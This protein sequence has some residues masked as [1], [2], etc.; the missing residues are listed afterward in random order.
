MEDSDENKK[1][2]NKILDY[3]NKNIHNNI[4]SF[5][6]N[7]KNEINKIIIY[8]FTNIIESINNENLYCYD[9]KTLGEIKQNN[10]KQIRISAIQNEFELETEIEEFLEN[11][12]LKLF[13]L[14]L[15]PYECSTID[16]LK[17]I[18]ENKETEYKNK[19]QEKINKL[20]LFIVHLERISKKDS[21]NK[22]S[23]NWDL[24]QKKTLTHSLS[25]LAGYTQVFID[26]ING[27]DYLD[28][29]CKIIS[30]EKMLKMK[31][32][33][34]YQ[35][36][37]N[38]E[39]IFLENL[40][41]VLFFYDYNFNYNE[42]ELNRDIYITK[43]I[44][45]FIEDK[46]LIN[47][48]DEK[49]MEII[50]SKN[51]DVN[52]K[53]KNILEKIIQEEKFSRG[54]I[55]IYDIVKK[56]L[57][58]N[59]LNE[60]KVLYT[61]L[62]K[63]YY[64]SNLIFNKK[65]NAN[66]DDDKVNKIIKEIF[67][68]NVDIKDKVP[69]NE[70]KI[71]IIIG[72]NLPSKNLIEEII[73][74][75]NNNIINQYRQN[76][77]EFKNQYFEKKQYEN[78]LELCNK[79]TQENIKKNNIIKEIEEKLAKGEKII[80]YDKF[81]DLLFEDYLLYFIHKN[82]KEFE[83]KK[84]INIK[85]FIK[86]ILENKFNLNDNKFNLEILS[87]L[88]NWIE[89]YSME[90]ISIINMYLFLNKYDKSNELNIKI[91]DTIPELNKEYDKLEISNNMKLI[92]RTFYNIIDSLINILICNLNKILSEIKNQESLKD[93]IDNLNNVY[94]SL[95]LNNNLLNLSSKGIHTLHETIKII[96]ILSFNESEENKKSMIDFI[97]K[98][99]INKTK[100][101][102][103]IIEG[104]KLKTDNDNNE[105]EDTEEEKY[106]K[107][108]LD[109]FYK[110]YKGK[111]N[112]N[113]AELFSSVLFDEFKKEYNEKYRQYLLKKILDDDN[114]IQYNILLIK[115]IIA[116]YIKPNKEIIDNVLDYISSEE[117]YFPFLNDC[118]K[119]IVNKIIINI[120][121]TTINLYFNSLDNLSENMISDLFDIFVEYLKVISN[122][123]YE[124]YYDNYCNEKLVK[125]Y[126]LSFIKIYLNNFV[127][128]LCDKRT[129][130][131]KNENKII[132]EI[133][134]NSSI[135]N[136]IKIYFIILLYNK[137]KS[138]NILKEDKLYEP[139][140]GFANNLNNLDNII[141]NSKIPTDDNY[142]FHEYFTYIKYPSFENLKSKFLSLYA[143]KEKFPLINEYIKNDQGPNN[144]KDLNDYNDF[145]NLMVSY[146]SG[147]IQRNEANKAERSLDNEDIYKKDENN[148][149]DKFDK[150][151]SIYNNVLSPYIKEI[152][153]KELKSDKF[154]EKLEANG[155]LAYFLID[156]DDKDYGIFIAI[157][158]NKFI[159]WQNSF[160][161]PIIKAYKS[162]K[163]NLLSCYFPQMEKEVNVQNA[164][165]LQ[166]LQLENCFFKSFFINFEELFSLY[167]E[168]NNDNKNDFNYDFEKIEEELGKCLLPNKCLFNE[169]NINYICY[170]NEGFRNIN[171]DYLIKFGEKYGE[172]ELTEE[173]RKKIFNYANKEFNNFD[174]LYDSFILL[175]NYLNNIS[176]TKGM[177][178]IDFI[179]QAQKRHINFSN[180]FI[181][182]FK[183][184]GKEIV[185]EKLLSSFLYMEHICYDHL[186]D[187]IDIKFK[188][189]FDKGQ[190]K[191]IEEYFASKFK[192]AIITQKE[193]ASAVR[194]FI[195]R[196]LLNDDKKEKIDSNLS[197]YDCLKRKYL[198]NNKI[199]SS[200]GN[201]LDFNDLIKKYLGSFKFA[202]EARYSLEFYNLIGEE[203]KNFIKEEKDKFAGKETKK[204][205]NIIVEP[206]KKVEK[207][208][209]IGGKKPPVPGGPKMKPKK[210]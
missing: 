201:N 188:S 180:Q 169:K 159:E 125:I 34:L 92:N 104:P 184:E 69:E 204:E 153:N 26:D 139:F 30:L 32:L 13:I 210:K 167:A 76:E 62:E 29:E 70:M 186:I 3:Y 54:D 7:F 40:Y 177:K 113:F 79:I 127:T 60:F 161:K 55:C 156:S 209:G 85:S 137:T 12:N 15:L 44:E 174:I 45:L 18:I 191:E 171:Y 50:N 152:N 74:N 87:A 38:K 132:E 163:N 73:L 27:K 33:E 56:I 181:N 134:N 168:R 203:E 14:N 86:I 165:N 195:I 164:N 58:K 170:Q 68:K 157:G 147:K 148:F 48:L 37:I 52:C 72:F 41:S 81:Y 53:N 59:Y 118:D 140:D 130:L 136:T 23:E 91:K 162:R 175:V 110:F 6:S 145:V 120:F 133:N 103:K 11:K 47:L 206:K 192:D 89:T 106:L 16:Y 22:Y 189:T 126:V 2:Y 166:I 119:D 172:K 42:S 176:T 116:E 4:K 101:K 100:E 25:N 65:N 24:I 194:R 185:I 173:E 205:N 64:F 200:L 107:N 19:N 8:T 36:F 20:F 1:F 96:S 141:K 77:E 82:I 80:F 108:N 49:I 146:Y 190:K 35:S 198:W 160:L 128:L 10:I 71:D 114:L 129:S 111:N 155:R 143:N 187:K 17:I 142:L 182:Y 150:F 154:L 197:L 93:L 75:I 31:N 179:N 109:N 112:I 5:L 117:N 158:L 115:L 208:S 138:L 149:R 151:K 123:D 135:S 144:L 199:F 28:N 88:L 84:I 183:E 66:N 105:T 122:N 124:K 99:I 63:N 61:E 207:T 178:I 51:D 94:Y 193:I 9:I 57:N 67:I 21:G 131:K 78:D 121:D 97:Q 202:L 102:N 90:I 98:K 83:L 43:L 39:N 196:Y 46:H 95:L